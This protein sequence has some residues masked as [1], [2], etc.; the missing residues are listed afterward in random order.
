MELSLTYIQIEANEFQILVKD[1]SLLPEFRVNPLPEL[2]LG[3]DAEI[4]YYLLT[5]KK[6]KSNSILSKA[7]LG[8]NALKKDDYWGEPFL[9]FVY[10]LTPNEIEETLKTI[11]KVLPE[12]FKLRI[13]SDILFY[14]KLFPKFGYKNMEIARKNLVEKYGQMI[15]FFQ[16]ANDKSKIIILGME[17]K[18]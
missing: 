2:Y 13:S 17:W 15:N 16:E 10:Y 4:I 11:R 12:E 5:G 7:F 3:F 18:K 9:G 6:E 14:R 8:H 1:L